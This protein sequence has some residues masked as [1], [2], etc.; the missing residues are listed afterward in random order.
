MLSN[1]GSGG[2]AA[3]A[4]TAGAGG[5]AAAAPAEEPKK[6]EKEEGK[7]IH[8]PSS[9]AYVLTC[10]YRREGGV[11]RGHGLGSLRLGG[12]CN[13]STIEHRLQGCSVTCIRSSA[14][15]EWTC[16]RR[17]RC[18]ATTLSYQRKPVHSSLVSRFPTLR[19]SF[20]PMLALPEQAFCSALK[21]HA[22]YRTCSKYRLWYIK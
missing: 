3:A 7:P 8:T 9:W 16:K 14:P 18:Y 10:C 21:H 11:G 2:G 5:A 20:L 22:N 15:W 17:S 6:E 19:L 1:V 12:S 13:V 4:S